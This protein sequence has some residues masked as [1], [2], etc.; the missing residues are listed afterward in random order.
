MA[1]KGASRVSTATKKNILV[2]FIATVIILLL[3]AG[4]VYY[5]GFYQPIEKSMMDSKAKIETLQTT[6]ET[7]KNSDARLKDLQKKL[8][9]LK[10]TTKPMAMFDNQPNL[11]KTFEQI[12]GDKAQWSFNPGQSGGT[13]GESIFRRQ[14]SLSIQNIENYAAAKEIVQKLHDLDYRVIVTG[15][16]FTAEEQTN[17]A[18]PENTPKPDLAKSK[19]SLAVDMTFLEK[20]NTPKVALPEA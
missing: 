7:A 6:L 17:A 5:F 8:T 2:N 11:I 15:V 16:S 4:L 13:G 9:D 12:I 20:I 14:V 18:N 19:I 1:I 10:T 3:V